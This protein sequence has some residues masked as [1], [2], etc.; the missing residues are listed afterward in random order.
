MARKRTQKNGAAWSSGTFSVYVFEKEPVTY[1]LPPST[2]EHALRGLGMSR[3]EAAHVVAVGLFDAP[4]PVAIGSVERTLH[5]LGLS[6]RQARAFMARGLSALQC[7]PT[8]PTPAAS[9]RIA[10]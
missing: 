8:A 3:R 5:D 4:P 10:Q 1:P 7:A 9:R 2:I 6:P